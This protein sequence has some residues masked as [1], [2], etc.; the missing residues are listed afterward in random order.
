[1]LLV[2]YREIGNINFDITE[3]NFTYYQQHHN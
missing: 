3:N 1:M 2:I